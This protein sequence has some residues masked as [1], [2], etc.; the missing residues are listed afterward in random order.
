MGRGHLHDG[1]T[2]G[3]HQQ[4]LVEP[5]APAD[6]GRTG[7]RSH[8]HAVGVGVLCPHPRSTD[9][10]RRGAGRP[11]HEADRADLRPCGVHLR[12]GARRRQPLGAGTHTEPGPGRRRGSHPGPGRARHPAR[13]RRDEGT[14]GDVHVA[15]GALRRSRHGPGAGRRRYRDTTARLALVLRRDDGPRDRLPGVG[16]AVPP[17]TRRFP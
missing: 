7:V 16:T 3:E 14:V 10:A 9:D 17:G 5:R 11:V 6:P 12:L 8:H 13:D 15:V 2:D 4:H 1:D